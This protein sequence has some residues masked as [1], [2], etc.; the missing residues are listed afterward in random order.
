MRNIHI[1]RQE[2][3]LQV[4]VCER[5]ERDIPGLKKHYKRINLMMDLDSLPDLDLQALLEFPPFDFA[6]DIC[7]IIRHMDRSSYP[8][9]LKDCFSPRC[10]RP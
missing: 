8:G 10:S 5:A 1:E 3:E 2:L 9:K 7:G 4:K 6:H